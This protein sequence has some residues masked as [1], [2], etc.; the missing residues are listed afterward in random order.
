MILNGY[1]EIVQCEWLKSAKIRSE[2]ELGDYVVMP[3]HFHGIV[4]IAGHKGNQGDPQLEGDP[5]VAPTI[6]L[7]TKSI[8]SMM[9][10]FKA[11]IT[12]RIN[13]IRETPGQPVWQRNYYEHV[14][15]S[16]AD[17]ANIAQYIANNPRCWTEDSLH[18]DKP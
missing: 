9:A 10:G 13:L 12:H 3:N 11:A 4:V 1:G 18:P 17:Y 8:G 2:I 16:E 7:K 6:G 5:P 15:R 14:I